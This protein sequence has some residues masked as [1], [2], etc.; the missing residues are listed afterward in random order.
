MAPWYLDDLDRF[1]DARPGPVRVLA[2]GTPT[3]QEP[4]FAR[5]RNEIVKRLVARGFRAI[6]VEPAG[7]R[8]RPADN[9]LVE[10]VRNSPAAL[11]ETDPLERPLFV[12]VHNR[13]LHRVGADAVIAG[14]LGASVA[15]GLGPPPP[16][17]F[18]G[19]LGA[20]VGHGPLFTRAKGGVTRVGA[21]GYMPLDDEMVALADAI[22]HV[23]RFPPAAAAL[24]DRIRRLP[25]VE[26]H[27][28]G[29]D[30]NVPDLAWDDQFFFVG[31]G[32]RHPFA[33]I[34]G[35]DLPGFDER[36][37]LDRAG[38]YR[39]NLDLGRREFRRVFGYGPEEL[40]A[41]AGDID[42]A[43]LDEFVPHPLY[44]VQSW[45]SVVNPG[46]RSADEVARLLDH[47]HNRHCG[48]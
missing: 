37:R 6:V 1:L 18:E 36:S 34:V 40:K 43:A 17:T 20:A 2:F 4:A 24:A 44:G 39:L 7:L 25:G 11:Y 35:H 31:S 45:A 30:D 14:S 3:H 9:D 26:Y 32:R 41:R 13:H 47:A 29:P 46:P 5:A 10:W 42:V 21:A 33:T 28:A 23:D 38:V 8:D 19:R 15:V 48:S 22:W 12:A 27:R 16:G